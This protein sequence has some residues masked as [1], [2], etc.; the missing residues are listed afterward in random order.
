MVLMLCDMCGLPYPVSKSYLNPIWKLS[1]GW[2][3]Y[4][5][6]DPINIYNYVV[7]T[8]ISTLRL[9]YSYHLCDCKTIVC[10]TLLFIQESVYVECS[11]RNM[12]RL[13]L[14]VTLSNISRR[15][16]ETS[17]SG[18]HIPLS[19]WSKWS[20]CNRCWWVRRNLYETTLYV[21]AENVTA[22]ICTY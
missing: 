21:N 13:T 3:P 16:L 2:A 7:E 9:F 12:V 20:T 19:E 8:F 17:Q 4:H 14:I 15:W 5:L 22:E 18:H 6:C 1:I 11:H 10:V